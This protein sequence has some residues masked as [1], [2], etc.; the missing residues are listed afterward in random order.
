MSKRPW[1]LPFSKGLRLDTL[2]TAERGFP[3]PRPVLLF[4]E[5]LSMFLCSLGRLQGHVSEAAFLLM[6]LVRLPAWWQKRG[7]GSICVL[8]GML[9]AAGP[10]API[11]GMVCCCTHRL[12]PTQPRLQL[13]ARKRLCA[14]H[15]VLLR[16]VSAKAEGLISRA[17]AKG[18]RLLPWRPTAP[19]NG[20]LRLHRGMGLLPPTGGCNV[21]GFAVTSTSQGMPGHWIAWQPMPQCGV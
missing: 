3:H 11:P 4:W 12:P 10:K 13:G 7:R 20:G 9:P 8:P 19:P 6:F 18:V 16:T 1:L 14:C 5:S 17:S 21:F 2:K 15:C